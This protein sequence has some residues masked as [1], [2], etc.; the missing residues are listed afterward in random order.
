MRQS[1]RKAFPVQTHCCNLDTRP[2]YCHYPGSYALYALLRCLYSGILYVLEGSHLPLLG[3]AFLLISLLLLFWEPAQALMQR[4][5]SLFISTPPQHD[6]QCGCDG[7]RPETCHILQD[8]RSSGG[9]EVSKRVSL[10]WA[11][12]WTSVYGPWQAQLC[13]DTELNLVA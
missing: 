11:F 12:R 2:R 3:V 5:S 9:G 10:G 8:P 6:F 1:S 4:V 7:P 13:V